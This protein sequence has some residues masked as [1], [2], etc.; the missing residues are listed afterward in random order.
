MSDHHNNGSR[1]TE[2]EEAETLADVCGSAFKI[3]NLPSL[4]SIEAQTNWLIDGLIPEGMVTLITG[5]SVVGKST[6][7]LAM[8]GA[9]AHGIPFLGRRTVCKRTLYVD[10]EKSR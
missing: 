4:W 5:D 3:E 8:V 6:L 9:V 2:A 1:L 7:A 10:G